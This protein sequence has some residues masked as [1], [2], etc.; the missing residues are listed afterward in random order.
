MEL[1]DEIGA[2]KKAN[3]VTI[4]QLERYNEILTRVGK[5]AE[6]LGF[7]KTA[8]HE[9]MARIHQESIQ[10]QTTIFND[11]SLDDS[12]LPTRNNV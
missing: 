2:Y 11:Q 6:E 12:S 1:S 4:L 7:D 9:I 10:R 8:I 5:L 3:D